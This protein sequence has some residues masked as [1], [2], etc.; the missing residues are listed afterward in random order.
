MGVMKL[1]KRRIG[2]MGGSFNPIHQGH[3][4]LAE[5]AREAFDLEKVLFIPNGNP[6]YSKD[7]F[8]IEPEYRMKMVELAIQN[9]PQ[10]EVSSIEIG[11]ETPCYSIDTLRLLQEKYPSILYQY[12][13][14]TGMDS[15][16]EFSSWKDP[17]Q[18][19]EMTEFIAGSRPGYTEEQVI[20]KIKYLPGCVEKVHFLDIPL[21]E[22][23]SSDIRNRIRAK[24]TIRYLV[25]DEVFTYI[26]EK[27]LYL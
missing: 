2:W 7:E 15:I 6:G 19:L 27:G 12:F 11:R 8:P 26:S 1:Y 4:V 14:I 21:L 16:S 24:K 18:V 13:F 22:I 20:E 17:I 10:F 5:N 3:L 25:P 23:S 9:H